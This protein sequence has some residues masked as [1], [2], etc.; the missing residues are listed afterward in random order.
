VNLLSPNQKKSIK[1]DKIVKTNNNN[2]PL[3]DSR[4]L[5][6][7][8]NIL[9]S[10]YFSKNAGAKGKNSKSVR[11]SCLGCSHICPSSY[12]QGVGQ[13]PLVLLPEGTDNLDQGKQLAL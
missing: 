1:L 7:R 3:Q 11:P 12:Q 2:K 10:I 5:P 4:N 6:N 9:K 13:K 8:D